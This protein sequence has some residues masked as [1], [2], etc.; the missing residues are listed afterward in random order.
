MI[1]TL[2]SNSS[3]IYVNQSNSAPYINMSNPSAGMTRYNSNTSS[4]EVYDGNIWMQI[5]SGASLSV[6]SRLETVVNWAM[7]RMAEEREELELRKHP[8]AKDAYDTYQ[9][10]LELVKKHNIGETI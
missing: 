8:L 10:T 1:K 3:L 6:D 7:Q 2:T 9:T 4:L 5:S